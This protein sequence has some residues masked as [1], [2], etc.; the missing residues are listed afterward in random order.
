MSHFYIPQRH[1]TEKKTKE[2]KVTKVT[3]VVYYYTHN[4]PFIMTS[5]SLVTVVGDTGAQ[6][7]AVVRASVKTGI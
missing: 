2:N 3:G 4:C 1:Q 7:N 5:R 6:E